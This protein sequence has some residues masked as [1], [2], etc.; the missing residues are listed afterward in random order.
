MAAR[1]L[2]FPGALLGL[3]LVAAACASPTAVIRQSEGSA[4][5][6][7]QTVVS[8]APLEFQVPPPEAPEQW[9]AHVTAWDQAYFDV[10][11]KSVAKLGVT[12]LVRLAPGEVAREGLVVVAV[13]R[14]I[15][16]GDYMSGDRII[17]DVVIVD[18]TSGK[19]RIDARLDVDSRGIGPEGYTFGGRIKFACLNLARAIAG[20]L[21]RGTFRQ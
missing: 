20:A 3:S 4:A 9:T 7:G 15:L 1:T 16:R 8:V 5:L 12:S 13:V 10:L 17:A 6:G 2:L 14:D 19:P 21:D 18:G 11:G